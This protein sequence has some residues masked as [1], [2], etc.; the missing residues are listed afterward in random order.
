MPLVGEGFLFIEQ[1]N[2]RIFLSEGA[3]L[4]HWQIAIFAQPIDE[5]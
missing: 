5:P 3:E 4:G 2:L 1:L